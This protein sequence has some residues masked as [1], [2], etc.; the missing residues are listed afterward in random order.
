MLI[1]WSQ[2]INKITLY[3]SMLYNGKISS[4][5]QGISSSAMYKL[6]LIPS[7]YSINLC[8]LRI[9]DILLRRSL[10]MVYL[11]ILAR[12]LNERYKEDHRNDIYGVELQCD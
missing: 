12:Q 4:I 7:L 10:S 5:T 6:L 11:Q 2:S 1:V 8:T 3:Y 9:L